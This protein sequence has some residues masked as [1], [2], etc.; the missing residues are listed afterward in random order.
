MGRSTG[1]GQTTLDCLVLKTTDFAVLIL[2][3][4][5][6][7]KWVPRKV[8]L[9]GSSIDDGDEDIVVADW[10]LKQEGLL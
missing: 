8:C 5:H 9:D 7:E 1:F 10:W 4:Q 3:D 6:E 2:T